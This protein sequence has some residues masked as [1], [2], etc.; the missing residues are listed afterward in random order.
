MLYHLIRIAI[1]CIFLFLMCFIIRRLRLNK[2][3]RLYALSAVLSVLLVSILYITPIENAFVTFR[4]PENAYFYNH[5]EEI[6]K[7]IS[8]EQ[9]DLI[10]SGENADRQIAIIPKA[11][12]G[13]KIGVGLDVRIRAQSSIKGIVVTVYQYKDSNDFYIHIFNS[14]GGMLLLQDSKSSSFQS[15]EYTDDSLKKA[16]YSYY[17]YIAG[18]DASYQVIVDDQIIVPLCHCEQ[19]AKP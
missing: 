1:G 2:S 6:Q 3:K 4:S 8:G 12:N 19:R 15:M 18:M 17:A 5:T 7:I 13:W 10:V 11:D 9:S 14:G 16:F